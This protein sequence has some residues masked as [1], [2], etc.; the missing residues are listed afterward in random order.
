MTSHN[1]QHLRDLLEMG[2]CVHCGWVDGI[3]SFVK[4]DCSSYRCVACKCPDVE[5]SDSDEG[6]EGDDSDEEDEGANDKP[7]APCSPGA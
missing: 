4:C 2:E 1:V 3:D 5:E 7:A 6:D